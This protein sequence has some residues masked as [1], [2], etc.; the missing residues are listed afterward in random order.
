M[1]ELTVD[2]GIS[3]GHIFATEIM[4]RIDK[5]VVASVGLLLSVS[6]DT[7]TYEV[8]LKKWLKAG[9]CK[10]SRTVADYSRALQAGMFQAFNGRSLREYVDD[11]FI[12]IISKKKYRPAHT[13]I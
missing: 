3:S 5:G 9:A 12:A 13:F 4:I 2:P 1:D 7:S 10:P 11:C 8:F 6:Q